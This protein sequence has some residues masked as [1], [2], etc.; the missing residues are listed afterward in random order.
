[1]GWKRGGRVY[2]VHWVRLGVQL[3]NMFAIRAC[4]GAI[5]PP[6]SN[7]ERII[8]MTHKKKIVSYSFNYTTRT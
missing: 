6:L 4:G 5:L 7:V 8:H 2:L 1:V 3:V